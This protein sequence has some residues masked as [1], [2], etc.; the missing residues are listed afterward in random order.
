LGYAGHLYL[1]YRGLPLSLFYSSEMAA[2]GTVID[3]VIYSDLAWTR[4]VGSAL[5]VFFLTFILALLPA[6]R[7]AT[8]QDVQLLGQV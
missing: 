7:G 1:H 2:A 4:V 5:I 6:W 8:G 3:P